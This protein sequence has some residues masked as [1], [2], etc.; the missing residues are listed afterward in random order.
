MHHSIWSE[1][2]QRQYDNGITV[3]GNI[4]LLLWCVLPSSLGSIAPRATP[5]SGPHRYNTANNRQQR[6]IKFYQAYANFYSDPKKSKEIFSSLLENPSL[7][8]DIKG[9]TNSNLLL[10]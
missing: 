7:E 2:P 4:V 5:L 3:I 6:M 1:N 8:D 10:I 9:W